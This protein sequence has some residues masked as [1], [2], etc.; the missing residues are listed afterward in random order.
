MAEQLLDSADIVAIF[1]Q[2]G[3]EG[4]PE[5]M[6]SDALVDSCQTG[7]FFDCLLQGALADV[8]AANDV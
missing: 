6:A 7:R 3:G 1:Q 4:V 8:M 5:G 2:V